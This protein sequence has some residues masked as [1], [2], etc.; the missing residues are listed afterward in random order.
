MHRIHFIKTTRFALLLLLLGSAAGC[1]KQKL[2]FPAPSPSQGVSEAGAASENQEKAAEAP[3][4]ARDGQ[5]SQSTAA[6]AET[7]GEGP[8]AEIE[9]ISPVSSY[10]YSTLSDTEKQVYR[11]VYQGLISG[12]ETKLSTLEDEVLKRAFKYVLYD[13]PEI[14]YTDGFHYSSESIGET[15]LSLSLIPQYTLSAAEKEET[16]ARLAEKL[17]EI[18][19]AA[20]TGSD[21]EKLRYAYDWVVENT[22]Y[23]VDAENGQ[24]VLSVFLG[25]QSVCNGYAKAFQLL[26]QKMGIPA[27]LVT[28]TAKSGSHAWVAACPDGVWSL[29]DPTWGEPGISNEAFSDI[30]FVNHSYF[31]LTSEDM[32]LDH[33]ALGDLTLPDC[34]DD[35]HSYFRQE[36]SY[37][38]NCDMETLRSCFRAAQENGEGAVQFRCEDAALREE[39]LHELLDNQMVYRFLNGRTSASYF[40][41]E[42]LNVVTFLLNSGE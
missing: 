33:A 36:G 31:A 25:G 39:F 4:E 7:D 11:E 15:R 5:D 10:A 27:V 35:S 22:D 1:Q 37:F 13:H 2:P 24:N 16:D 17:A 26:L 12:Q 21:Y 6:S 18:L 40:V 42:G 8:A 29:F 34:S 20:P 14:Y 23:A 19:E 41:N 32:G 28:G 38:T 9:D 3:S 30:R